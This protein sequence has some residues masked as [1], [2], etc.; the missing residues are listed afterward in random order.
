MEFL[1]LRNPAPLYLALNALFRFQLVLHLSLCGKG[2]TYNT[3]R[4]TVDVGLVR[5]FVFVGLVMVC[6]RRRCSKRMASND[7][8]MWKAFLC[9]SVSVVVQFACFRRRVA[10]A[11]LDHRRPSPHINPLLCFVSACFE[12]NDAD[13]CLQNTLPMM[14]RAARLTIFFNVSGICS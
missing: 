14:L 2:G 7:P 4:N 8:A 5:Y 9:R 13:V 11:S 10:S 6:E 12:Q 3:N 1:F